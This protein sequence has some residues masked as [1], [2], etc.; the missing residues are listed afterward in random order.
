M[1]KINKPLIDKVSKKSKASHRNRSNINFHKCPQ[2]F[3]QRMLCVINKDSYIRPHK[4]EKPDKAEVF[5]VLK[6]KAL[7]M[8]FNNAGKIIDFI[9]LDA[10]ESFGV[11]FS[12]KSW[13]TI[14]SL[15][16]KTVL[17]E[18][19]DGPYDPGTDKIFAPWSFEENTKGAKQFLK[20]IKNQISAKLK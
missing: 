15:K 19:K 18:I 8:E 16:N 2:D 3:L 4:H 13:H 20:E 12:P 5:I 6:G 7:A 9:I 10:K 17:Y 14:V 1:I 11:E